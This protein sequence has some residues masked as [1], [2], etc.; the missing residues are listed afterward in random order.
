MAHG[1][2]QTGLNQTDQSRRL[3]WGLPVSVTV[4][5]SL[6]WGMPDDSDHF[7]HSAL[8]VQTTDTFQESGMSL[9]AGVK[10]QGIN[11][12]VTG[13]NAAQKSPADSTCG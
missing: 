6:D 1:V 5:H 7:M 2:S 10:N 12:D 8:K 3:P 13:L 9:N 4:R 11:L